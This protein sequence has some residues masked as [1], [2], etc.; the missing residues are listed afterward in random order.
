MRLGWIIEDTRST[1]AIPAGAIVT[2]EE[3]QHRSE[4]NNGNAS[5]GHTRCNLSPSSVPART[6]RA[7]A[8]W[9]C[10]EG[11]EREAEQVVAHMVFHRRLLEPAVS[12]GEGEAV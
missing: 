8:A 10:E 2:R 6:L 5:T 9:S 7:L 12:G 11:T 3:K 1:K 4:G